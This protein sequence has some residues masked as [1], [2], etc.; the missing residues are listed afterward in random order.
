MSDVAE[1]M[2]DL[3]RN[4]QVE[5]QVLTRERCEC[6][7][8]QWATFGHVSTGTF[9]CG[10]CETR[11]PYAAFSLDG[12]DDDGKDWRVMF[13][14]ADEDARELARLATAGN[15]TQRAASYELRPNVDLGAQILGT[16]DEDGRNQETRVRHVSSGISQHHETNEMEPYVAIGID[17]ANRP[18]GRD[19]FLMLGED[20]VSFAQGM[21][22][23]PPTERLG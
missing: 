13:F 15:E 9:L 22:G 21:Q 3:S 10:S 11:H 14:L 20:A 7:E 4:T 18:G 5:A 19:L 12:S 6:G 17:C 16:A 23:L 1:G 2:P 8:P